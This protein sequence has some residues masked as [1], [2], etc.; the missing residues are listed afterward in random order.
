M[1]QKDYLTLYLESH[2]LSSTSSKTAS[3]ASG[4]G[5]HRRS[6][7]LQEPYT[8]QLEKELRTAAE[9]GQALL[10]RQRNTSS[11]N[12]KLRMKIDELNERLAEMNRENLRILHSNDE[13]LSTQLELNGAL[14]E[15]NIRLDNL[16]DELNNAR[17]RIGKMKQTSISSSS[18][19]DQI[20]YLEENRRELYTE[21]ETMRE[22]KRMAEIAKFKAFRQLEQLQ[23]QY[24]LL[25]SRYT[26]LAESHLCHRSQSPSLC[27]VSDSD[28]ER[29]SSTAPTTPDTSFEFASTDAFPCMNHHD[30]LFTPDI[31]SPIIASKPIPTASA[32]NVLIEGLSSPSPNDTSASLLRK[33]FK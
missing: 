21:L 14:K 12:K 10:Q 18:L 20:E 11:E 30:Y 31:I 22:D 9:V 5:K 29:R 3:G 32:S 4:G 13:L 33:I 8:K 28:R 16:T 24:N 1:K 25:E 26:Q 23:D 17:V 19:Q 2:D 27:M 15:S 7:S 6:R